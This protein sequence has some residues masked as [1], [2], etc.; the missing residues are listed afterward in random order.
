MIRPVP[1]GGMLHVHP[2]ADRGHHRRVHARPAVE[3]KVSR[4]WR[5]RLLRGRRLLLGDVVARGEAL[6]RADLGVDLRLRD[7]SSASGLESRSS[8]V[9]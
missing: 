6:G 1:V 2:G 9:F 5:L 7:R 4:G 3:R 8:A